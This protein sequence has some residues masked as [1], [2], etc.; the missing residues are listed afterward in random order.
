MFLG[1]IWENTLKTGKIFAP[2]NTLRQH[3]HPPGTTRTRQMLPT[4]RKNHLKKVE[5]STISQNGRHSVR[6]VVFSKCHNFCQLPLKSPTNWQRYGLRLEK[7]VKQNNSPKSSEK[8]RQFQNVPAR[9]PSC[10][11]FFFTFHSNHFR[12]ST[13][14]TSRNRSKSFPRRNRKWTR[15]PSWIW[16]SSIIFLYSTGSTLHLSKTNP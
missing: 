10:F 15:P 11:F 8:S 16:I 3:T 14:P 1:E 9:P 2:G 13:K 7:S 6:H 12:P 5:N 4:T